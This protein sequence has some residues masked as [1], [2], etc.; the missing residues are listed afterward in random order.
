VFTSRSKWAL[1][2]SNCFMDSPYEIDNLAYQEYANAR[3]MV[4]YARNWP[5]R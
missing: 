2:T 5:A 1:R 3:D 4:E